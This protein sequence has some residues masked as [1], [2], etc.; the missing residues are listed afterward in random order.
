MLDRGGLRPGRLGTFGSVVR[1]CVQQQQPAQEAPAPAPQPASGLDGLSVVAERLGLQ[2]EWLESVI[3]A[4]SGGKPDAVN[5]ETGASGIIQWLP[6]TARDLGTTVEA[7]RAMTAEEQMPL[8]E[9][10]LQPYAKKIA[11]LED[12]HLAVFFPA[13][14][15][16][17]N[18]YVL[19]REGSEAYAKN[20]LLDR[21]K[22]GHVT[23][24]D[25]LQRI[26]KQGDSQ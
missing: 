25:L 24:G 5:E 13:A 22:K 17:D 21:G 14:L 12:A 10:Y 7:I 1:S 26:K 6:S 8:V 23:R 2:R 16:R 19:F 4:E 11:S 3:D 9:Q 20:H 18:S 15:G